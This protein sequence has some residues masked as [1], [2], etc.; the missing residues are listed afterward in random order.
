MLAYPLNLSFKLIALSSQIH[1]TDA[2]GRLVAYVK[3]QKFKLKEDIGIFSDESQQQL[4]FRIKADRVIDFNA[5]Y[6]IFTA[7]GQPIGAVRRQGMRSFWKATYEIADPSGAALGLIHEEN[8][9]VK[10]LDGLVGEVP[11]LGMFTG[12]F[13][14]PAYLVDFRGGTVLYVKKQPALIEGK[15]TVEARAPYAAEDEA[16]LLC[17]TIMALILERFRG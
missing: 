15:F 14:N 6:T 17:G 8:A 10:V 16:L 12:Y 13:F 7:T 5:N 3:Q 11:V 1:V 9:W 2:T 4:L